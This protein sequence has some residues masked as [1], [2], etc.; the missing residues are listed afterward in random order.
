MVHVGRVLNN[1]WYRY[2]VKHAIM[3]WDMR[4]NVCWRCDD[5]AKLL[6]RHALLLDSMV[7]L[8]HV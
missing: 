2:A 8:G 7:H 1:V 6:S 5:D 4:Y 3:C